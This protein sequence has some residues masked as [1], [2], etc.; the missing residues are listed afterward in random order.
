MVDQVKRLV[1]KE[2]PPAEPPPERQWILDIL[3]EVYFAENDNAIKPAIARLAFDNIS[4]PLMNMDTTEQLPYIFDKEGSTI[5]QDEYFTTTP[6]DS[7]LGDISIDRNET[8]IQGKIAIA[9]DSEY[10]SGYDN[11]KHNS[12]ETKRKWQPT[13]TKIPERQQVECRRMMDNYNQT[14]S[15]KT[16]Q[17]KIRVVNKQLQNHHYEYV[18]GPNYHTTKGKM[19]QLKQKLY[20]MSI[21]PQFTNGI[22]KHHLKIQNDSGAN[23]CV[24]NAKHL[25]QRYQSIEPY[26]IAGIK[27][28]VAAIH[29]TGLGYLP[30][31]TDANETLLIRCYYSPDVAGTIISPTDVVHQNVDRFNSWQFSANLDS[32]IGRWRMMARDGLNHCQFTAYNEN[33]LWWHYS[34]VSNITSTSP[35]NNRMQG[36]VNS[37][38]S[39]ANY[40]LW[41]HR[42]GH[43]GEKVMSLVH[44]HVK[45][46]PK[47]T[48]HH[49]F[50]C[51]ACLTKNLRKN[52]IGDI[53]H[54][55]KNNKGGEKQNLKPGQRLHMD[56]GFVRG[57][58]WKK[59]DNDGKLVTSIDNYRSYLLIIDKAT[60]YSYV[61][62]TKTKTPPLQEVRGILTKYKG[63]YRDCSVTTDN[64]GELAKSVAFR[65]VIR[66][67]G[68]TLKTTGAFSSAQNGLVEKPNQDLAR[69]MRAL[70]YSSNLG[71]QYWSY[72][73][74][75][76][77]YLKNRL[78]HSA[79][80]WKT[81]YEAL[82]GDK[83]DLSKLKS[84]GARVS[85]HS[86]GRK[87]KLD[88]ISEVGT[89]L[90]YK[91]TDKV[92]YVR[93]RKTGR[94][95]TATH[96]YF[97]EAFMAETTTNLP[98]MALALQQAGYRSIPNAELEIPPVSIDDKT[99]NIKLLTPT[100]KMPVRG[101]TQ[102]AGLD[103]FSDQEVTI[104]RGQQHILGTSV[105]MEIPTGTFGK[106]EIRSGLAAKHNLG[107]V[108]GV[109]GNDYRGEI[110][111]IVR[112]HGEHEFKISRGDRIAQLLLL[113]QQLYAYKQ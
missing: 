34:P 20:Q 86:G 68:Y 41:H 113:P 10:Q 79:L 11:I 99:L 70:L 33:N 78:P 43:P 40:Q 38:S 35:R 95:K 24:T 102:A 93:D 66:D 5:H 87:A 53:K 73:L 76:A 36:T 45:G 75:H 110:K 25:L 91:G 67:A 80:Q 55:I 111:I 112:N 58:D 12:L 77:V 64:G 101:T 81:P 88:D 28:D 60:R 13:L 8:F 61:F 62:L 94:E 72:A 19:R 31:T 44:K 56:F 29:C 74:R 97:D 17:G 23:R 106:L 1:D 100:A 90:T 32:G 83:P 49:F 15:R 108:A 37:L 57:S 92:I 84:F 48:K 85:V 21:L 51:A 98:P 82:L 71:S 42:L 50:N 65:R 7:E 46:V 6:D 26:P 69:I 59:T 63:L 3:D 14:A 105:A 9:S 39:H 27:D 47:L 96:A 103:L 22:Y 52:H 89:F 104:P 107:I 18:N 30:M 4:Q 2:Q 16:I 109:I 54:Y